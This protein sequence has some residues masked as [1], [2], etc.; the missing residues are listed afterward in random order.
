MMVRGWVD[1]HHLM[2]DWNNVKKMKTRDYVELD[3]DK[4]LELNFLWIMLS[5]RIITV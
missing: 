4:F 1:G 3:H 2:L 5:I